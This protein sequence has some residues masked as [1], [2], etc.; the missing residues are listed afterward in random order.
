MRLLIHD[1]VGHPFP[2]QLSRELA[3]QGH[4]V[5]HAYPH[6]PQDPQADLIKRP[7]DA[8]TLILRQ[9]PFRPSG[10]P[11]PT[12]FLRRRRLEVAYG[13]QV[14]RLVGTWRPDGV[15]SVHTPT[16]PQGAILKATRAL[17]APFLF[18]L[19]NFPSLAVDREVR[20]Q[21]PLLG[22]LVGKAYRWI[23][24]RQ[25]RASHRVVI[26]AP[27]FA[28][29]LEQ[30]F[31]VPERR[32][33]IIPNLAPLED[34]P[35]T[36]QDNPWSRRHR[37][38]NHFVYLY[39]GSLTLSQH[40]QLLLDLAERTRRDPQVRV[41]VLSQGPGA[42]WLAAQQKTRQLPNLLLLPYQNFDQ[43]PQV[44]ASSAVLL[45]LL[46]DTAETFLFPTKILSYLCAARP[47]LL[48]GPASNLAARLIRHEDL[49]LTVPPADSPAFL[50]A[51]Q[52]LRDQPPLATSCGRRA[53]H[54]AEHHFQIEPI[55]AKFLQL[56]PPSF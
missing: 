40:P 14:A 30:D 10:C 43:M 31:R 8:P 29:F 53:R 37:L 16:A 25:L 44:L 45:T 33:A 5:L 20:T 6:R 1:Y 48:A 11:A 32:I 39:T 17:G 36:P 41:V 54:Y 50:A 15:I 7:G 27:D 26:P 35:E 2:L 49:G 42:D 51:A 55:A 46:A 12:S 13:R 56:F 21:M 24:G 18:W 19:Q 9:L 3:H 22:E 34:L 23:E 4:E 28:P 52:R 38:A 47:L